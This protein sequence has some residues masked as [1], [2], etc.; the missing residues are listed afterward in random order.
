MG[1]S[2][3]NISQDVKELKLIEYKGHKALVVAVNNGRAKL[4]KVN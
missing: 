4:I 1:A 2:G 3:L